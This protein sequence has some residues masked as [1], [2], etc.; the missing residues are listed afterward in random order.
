MFDLNNV[1]LKVILKIITCIFAFVPIRMLTTE[2]I[3]KCY[4]SKYTDLKT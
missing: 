1:Y 4:C 2:F 3:T